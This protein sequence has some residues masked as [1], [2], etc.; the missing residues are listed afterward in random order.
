[1]QVAKVGADTMLA[2]IIRLVQQ[3]QA[4]KRRSSASPSSSSE[5]RRL[6]YA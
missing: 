6:D 4:P 5:F 3:A 2:Q 1:V